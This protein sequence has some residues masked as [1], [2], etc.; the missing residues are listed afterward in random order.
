MT[1]K[2]KQE[3]VKPQWFILV[4]VLVLTVPTAAVMTLN[5][6]ADPF[7]LFFR[8]SPEKAVFLSK[9]G[10]DRYQMPGVVQSYQPNSI[11]V[12]HSLAANFQPTRVERLLNWSNVYNLTLKGSPIYEH[13]RVA[14][15]AL[16]NADIEKVL[17]LFF[18]HNLRLPPVVYTPKMTFPE[19]LYDESRFNDLRFFATL[20][21]N[22]VGDIEEKE[23]VR[24]QLREFSEQQGEPVDPRDYATN[25]QLTQ[26]NRFN[27]KEKIVGEILKGYAGRPDAYRRALTDGAGHLTADAIASLPIDPAAD[28][29]ENVELNLRTTV[30]RNPDVEFMFIPMPPLTTLFWQHMRLTDPETYRSNLARLREFVTILS[31]YDNVSIHAFGHSVLSNDIRLYRDHGHYHMAVNEVMLDELAS[32]SAKVDGSTINQYLSD[33]DQRVLDY[34]FQDYR[35]VSI[36]GQAELKPGELSLKKGRQIVAAILDRDSDQSQEKQDGP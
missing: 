12:G 30:A 22:L 24:V 17:W 2:D 18:P 36:P 11:I 31:T 1:I 34:R 9:R 32:G 21:G 35:E 28:F 8:D 13:R 23:T 20:P 33:F 4:L 27:A 10:K 25:W 14:T 26:E 16:A 19:Y 5:L 7:Q 3:S 6:S 15:Y 29:W